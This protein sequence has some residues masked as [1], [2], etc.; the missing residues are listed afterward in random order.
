MVRS[1]QEDCS[2]R[3]DATFEVIKYY[4]LKVQSHMELLCTTGADKGRGE[5]APSLSGI[6]PPCRPKGSPSCTFLR[7]RF[8]V[9]NAKLFLNSPLAPIYTKFDGGADT[10]KRNFL[11]R[12]F[13]KVRKN[14]FFACF[15]KILSQTQEI[16]P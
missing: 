11:V 6:R 9:T 1:E 10:K 4:M 14:A 5:D 16:W 15:F 8:F 2:Y 7:N 13:Q 12:I 3:S